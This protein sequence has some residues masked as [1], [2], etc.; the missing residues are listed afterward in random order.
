M[1]CSEAGKLR[2]NQIAVHPPAHFLLIALQE[3]LNMLLH[4]YCSA[5]RVAIA[6]TLK[7]REVLGG[8]VDRATGFALVIPHEGIRSP[9]LLGKHCGDRRGQVHISGCLS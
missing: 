5:I 2:L 4:S 1:S 6:D 3:G 7:D 9:E 8:G